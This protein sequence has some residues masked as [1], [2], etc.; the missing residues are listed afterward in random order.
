MC[1]IPR[2]LGRAGACAERNG[3]ADRQ[4]KAVRVFIR[5]YTDHHH[6]DRAGPASRKFT[7][8]P[9]KSRHTSDLWAGV[10]TLR[11]RLWH[12]IAK[13]YQSKCLESLRSLRFPPL[14]MRGRS[15]STALREAAT[16]RNRRAS[17]TFLLTFAAA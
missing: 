14:Q 10:F 12:T 3:S 9:A 4:R 7:V 17:M 15:L 5:E 16:S 11:P 13:R 6:R 2:I 8:Y 1:A